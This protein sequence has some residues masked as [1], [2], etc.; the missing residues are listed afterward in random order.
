MS[1][2]KVISI[3]GDSTGK[4]RMGEPNQAVI[5]HLKELLQEAESGSIQGIVTVQLY[6]NSCAS[7]NIKGLI[8]GY[9]IIGALNVALNDLL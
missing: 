9:S 5:D 2:D 6:S 7:W 4:M 1:D 8:G 3:N